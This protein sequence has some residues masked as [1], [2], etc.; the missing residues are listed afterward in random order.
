M[1]LILRLGRLIIRPLSGMPLERPGG[2][3]IAFVMALLTVLATGVA[4]LQQDASHK[5]DQA[6]RRAELIANEAVGQDVGS[7]VQASADYGVYRRWYEELLRTS[8]A[9]TQLQVNPLGPNAPYLQALVSADA[10]IAAWTTENATLLQPPYFDAATR[11][12]DFVSYGADRS[13]ATIR[14]REQRQVEAEASNAWSAKS[15]SYITVLT[16]LAVALFFLGISSTLSTQARFPLAAAGTLIGVVSLGWTVLL[17]LDG[18]DRVPD[19]SIEQVVT[20]SVE[21]QKGTGFGRADL[22]PGRPHYEASIA[23]ANSA[24]EASPDYLSAYLIRAQAKLQLGNTIISREGDGDESRELIQA[25]Y[26]DYRVYSQQRPEDPATWWNLGVTAYLAGDFQASVDAST[27][28]IEIAP[29]QFPVYL[30]RALAYLALNNTAGAD[31][32]VAKGIEV[33]VTSGLDSNA[34]FFV[35]EDFGLAKAAERREKLQRVEEANQIRAIQKRLR[36]AYVALRAV[37]RPDPDP[38]APHVKRLDVVMIGVN[39]NGEV[40]A[41][42]ALAAGATVQQADGSG[43]RLTLG[44][45]MDRE[46]VLSI[47]LFADGFQDA[48]YSIDQTIAAGESDHLIDLLSPYGRAGFPLQPGQYLVEFYIDGATR[49]QFAWTVAA[50]G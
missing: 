42:N 46:R 24:I 49:G 5:D 28:S 30:N 48:S 38:N 40:A 50:P 4:G 18:V 8:W 39:V 16:L 44:L 11:V 37:G 9:Q 21:S 36:E 10:A 31:A 2:A 20:A 29:K 19:A 33:A 35:Q 32:D 15:T 1:G 13:A 26:D 22:K 25:A 6:N 23:A 3:T 17:A 14:A 34:S 12:S 43:V 47:R 45:A 27:K 41:G 7:V